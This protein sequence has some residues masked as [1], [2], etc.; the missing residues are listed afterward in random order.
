[1]SARRP[2]QRRL[3]A[4]RPALEPPAGERLEVLRVEAVDDVGI[5]RDVAQV[6]PERGERAD[7][8]RQHLEAAR[9][10][11]EVQ[12]RARPAPGALLGAAAQ[13]QEVAG[14][15]RQQH[16]RHRGAGGERGNAVERER[17][18]GRHRQAERGQ[19]GELGG[20]AAEG[21]DAH[22]LAGIEGDDGVERVA[23]DL[24]RLHCSAA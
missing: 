19:A 3:A 22:G 23:G 7:P 1:M 12:E 6:Q 4:L 15:E 16:R 24:L 18:A 13:R 5:G 2:L 9:A 20:A 11:A 17:D 10:G 8:V 21:A 14:R